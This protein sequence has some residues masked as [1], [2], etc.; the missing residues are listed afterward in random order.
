MKVEVEIDNVKLGLMKQKDLEEAFKALKE[1][2]GIIWGEACYD[3]ENE[4]TRKIC[5][6][7]LPYITKAND[8][9]GFKQ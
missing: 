8:I 3:P 7:M 2:Y 9:L 1:V 4:E 5:Q 6:K